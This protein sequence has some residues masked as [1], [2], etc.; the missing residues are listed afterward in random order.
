[1]FSTALLVVSA[2]VFLVIGI[3]FSEQL[4]SESIRL[5]EESGRL[6]EEFETLFKDLDQL[7]KDL[8]KAEKFSRNVIG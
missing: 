6:K 1:M 5:E 7:Q 4:E 2:L 3:K 8:D